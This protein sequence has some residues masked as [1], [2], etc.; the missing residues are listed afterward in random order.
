MYSKSLWPTTA[1]MN[2]Y[3]ITKGTTTN[4]ASRNEKGLKMRS[5]EKELK[6]YKLLIHGKGKTSWMIGRLDGSWQRG[7]WF[8]CWMDT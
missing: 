3:L 6:V 5:R 8:L 1:I 4:T 7:T 2:D